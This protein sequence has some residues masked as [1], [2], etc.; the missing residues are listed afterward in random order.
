MEKHAQTAGKKSLAGGNL[1]VDIASYQAGE[2]DSV[3]GTV[4]MQG[5][6]KL[7]VFSGQQVPDLGGQFNRFG[8]RLHHNPARTFHPEQSIRRKGAT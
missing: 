4:L 1:I 3:D 6:G 7:T 5:V 8:G 2:R